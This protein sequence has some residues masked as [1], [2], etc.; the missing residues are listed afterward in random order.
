MADRT[1]RARLAAGEAVIGTFVHLGDPAIVEIVAIAGFDFAILDTEHSSRGPEAV[2]HM[3]RA[4]EA[5]GLHLIVRVPEGD[6][7]AI[8]RALD[9]GARG[10]AVPFVESA[11]DVTAARAS[12]RYAPDGDRGTC[13]VTRAARYG[14]LRPNFA[15]HANRQNE[16]ILLVGLIESEAG[17]ER[18]EEILDAGLDV[19]LIGRGDLTAALGVTAQTEHP[20]VVEAV[21][22]V[23]TAARGRDGT[24]AGILPYTAEEGRRWVEADCPFLAY[25]IDTYVLL[26]AYTA[27][28]RTLRASIAEVPA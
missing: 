15:E 25:S 20:R 5:F 28:A 2:E 27:A 16:D 18:I 6:R 9:A 21:E 11:A 17:V 3:I 7:A 24:W 19:A 22:R 8:Q 10:I 26:E 1:L 23:L 4:A 13:T 14:A 12:L